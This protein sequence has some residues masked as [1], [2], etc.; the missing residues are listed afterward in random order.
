MINPDDLKGKYLVE[1]TSDGI[2]FY[3][4][5]DVDNRYNNSNYTY[6]NAKTM[7]KY[8]TP[9]TDSCQQVFKVIERFTVM[10]NIIEN[11][12]NKG[13]MK[14]ITEEEFDELIHNELNKITSKFKTL[15]GEENE[16]EV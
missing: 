13:T 16:R 4:I 2:I 11:G 8:D 10:I 1:T 9:Y 12:L 5:K 7:Y 14:F 15:G 6:M 3:H